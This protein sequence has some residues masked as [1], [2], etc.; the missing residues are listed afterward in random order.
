MAVHLLRPK[1]SLALAPKHIVL[2]TRDILSEFIKNVLSQEHIKQDMISDVL[3]NERITEAFTGLH[4]YLKQIFDDVQCSH[5]ALYE[6]AYRCYETY[7][8]GDA[9]LSDAYEQLGQAIYRQ[10]KEAE[11]YEGGLL[12]FSF[13]RLLS[14]DIVVIRTD[15]RA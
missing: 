1:R 3:T 2:D 11:A 7:D 10:L 5:D 8:L 15:I 9:D 6:I 4:L 13:H 14:H 12:Q